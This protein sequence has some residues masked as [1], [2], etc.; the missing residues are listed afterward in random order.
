L[1]PIQV[2]KSLVL[3]ATGSGDAGYGTISF[4]AW[5]DPTQVATTVAQDLS[6]SLKGVYY[7]KV[8]ITFNTTDWNQGLVQENTT[9][10][11]HELGHAI[12]DLA[13]GFGS[14]NSFKS[15]GWPFNSASANNTQLVQDNCT[16][17]IV[18]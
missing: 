12:N 7:Q 1:D 6:V 17:K 9:A 14:Q 13:A 10:L 5:A 4:A 3:A 8:L 2:L 15:D 11:L 16:R 18:F